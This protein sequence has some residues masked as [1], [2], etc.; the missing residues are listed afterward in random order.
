MGGGHQCE[1][2]I[3]HT[4]ATLGLDTTPTGGM[5]HKTPKVRAHRQG[6]GGMKEGGGS[7]G[8]G[9]GSERAGG[10]GERGGGRGGVKGGRG[11][12]RGAG[13]E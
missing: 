5:A 1:L 7:E 13:G 11:S 8:A 2:H 10:G 3:A 6:E 12:E 4:T 9:G